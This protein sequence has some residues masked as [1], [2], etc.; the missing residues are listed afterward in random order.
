MSKKERPT[1]GYN[2]KEKQ[3]TRYTTQKK[4]FTPEDQEFQSYSELLG[5]F[6]EKFTRWQKIFQQK[7]YILSEHPLHESP[8]G[9]GT[10]TEYW[11]SQFTVEQTPAGFSLQAAKTGDP[12]DDRSPE[13]VFQAEM[14]YYHNLADENNPEDKKDG[15]TMITIEF[16]N[17][18]MGDSQHFSLDKE[19][20]G[21]HP[22][23]DPEGSPIQQVRIDINSYHGGEH[24][25]ISIH[26]DFP[27]KRVDPS[28]EQWETIIRRNGSSEIRLRQQ[29][30]EH[31]VKYQFR[32]GTLEVSKYFPYL[33]NSVLMSDDYADALIKSIDAFIPDINNFDPQN[34]DT[35]LPKSLPPA[36]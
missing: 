32:K 33:I 2:N 24:K 14:R 4:V 16:T 5:G 30:K 20:V 10:F 13:K 7:E 28:Q 11:E 22:F 25:E 18:L 6:L 15:F 31:D 36:R 35:N 1:E 3:L 8:R 17:G 9:S 26:T 12:D 23:I 27:K 34:E 21:D 29:Y 19:P